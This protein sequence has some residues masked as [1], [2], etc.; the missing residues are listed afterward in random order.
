[1]EAIDRRNVQ[2]LMMHNA[3]EDRYPY[4]VEW[5]KKNEI[6][7]YK[8]CDGGTIDAIE[9]IGFVKVQYATYVKITESSTG[10]EIT[11]IKG[12]TNRFYRTFR[13]IAH[14]TNEMLRKQNF[15]VPTT[16]NT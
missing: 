12:K 8:L 11:K 5:F 13:A 1:M 7:F 10:N 2:T 9:Q 15:T 6:D 3:L 14:Y 16:L 4:I